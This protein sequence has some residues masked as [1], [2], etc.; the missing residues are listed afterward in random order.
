MKKLI[1]YF[2]AALTAL[3]VGLLSVGSA[4]QAQP[5]TAQ[6]RAA[7][8]FSENQSLQ[9]NVQYYQDR[10]PHRGP[11]RYNHHRKGHQDWNGHRPHRKWDRPHRPYY[12]PHFRPAPPRHHRERGYR[13]GGN[14]HISWCYDRYRS[15]RASDNTF[16]PNYGPRRLCYSPFI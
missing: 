14:R 6:H 9:Q 7:L 2:T 15:Y 10:R 3:T 12:Q 11:P 5:V 1:C 4:S 8:H 13:A 16:Q